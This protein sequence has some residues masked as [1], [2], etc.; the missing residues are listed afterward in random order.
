M[1]QSCPECDTSNIYERQTKVPTYRCKNGHTFEEPETR[2]H[3]NVSGGY[4]EKELVKELQRLADELE[5]Y[6]PTKT[7]MDEYGEYYGRTYQLRFGSWSEAVKTA[8]FTPRDPIDDPKDR[9]DGCRLCNTADT[10]LDFHHWRYGDNELGCYLCRECHDQIHEGKGGRHNTDWLKHCVTNTV[11][12]HLESGGSSDLATIKEQYN[13][14]DID[15]LIKQ[16]LENY[17]E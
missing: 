14:P 6:P 9:P 3:Y 7:E 4:T 10:G 16:T 8:G 13:F 11:E 1:L 2:E 15:V 17:G 5:R 12:L